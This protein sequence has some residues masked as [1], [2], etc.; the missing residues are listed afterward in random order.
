M[1]EIEDQ[2]RRYVVDEDLLDRAVN[3]TETLTNLLYLVR[4]TASDPEEV[5]YHAAKAEEILQSLG[6]LLKSVIES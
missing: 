6:D 5:G 2:P 3:I 1:V 4:M